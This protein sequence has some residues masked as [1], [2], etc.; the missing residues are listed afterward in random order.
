MKV[1][2]TLSFMV[3]LSALSMG[4]ACQSAGHQKAESTAMHMEDLSAAVTSMKQKAS[5][6]A[7]TLATVVEKGAVDPKPPFEQY[8][9]D[10]AAVVDGLANAESH[11]KSMKAEGQ[12]YFAEWE[13]QSATIQDADLRKSADERRARLSKAVEAVSTAMDAARA[14]IKPFVATIQDVQT[15][16]SNDLTPDGIKSVGGKSKQ[17]GKDAK[18]IGDKLDDVVEA[19]EKGAPEFKTA[20]PPPPPP[21]EKKG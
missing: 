20:K 11:L 7:A 12:T 5:S 15:Y 10:V 8:K 17:L 3:L 21:P 9:K 19:L 6:C 2:S 14:E 18:S 1:H 13:K 16:L 4:S